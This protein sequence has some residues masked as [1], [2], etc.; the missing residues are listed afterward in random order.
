MK[1]CRCR[2]RGRSKFISRTANSKTAMG[3]QTSI[4][5]VASLTTF[6][7]WLFHDRRHPEHPFAHLTK[8]NAK[9]DVRCVRRALSREEFTRLVDAATSLPRWR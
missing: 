4:H 3:P 6:G 2:V 1:P 9:V 7:N 5:F 8:V